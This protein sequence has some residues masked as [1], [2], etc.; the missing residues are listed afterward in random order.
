MRFLTMERMAVDSWLWTLGWR[1][2]AAESLA[3]GSWLWPEPGGRG[4]T[5]VALRRHPRGSQEVEQATRR[6]L[7]ARDGLEAKT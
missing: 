6:H 2:L 5:Q 1:F 4:E 3:V 7:E